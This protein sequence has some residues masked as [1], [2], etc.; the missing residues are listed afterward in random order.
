MSFLRFPAI[1]LGLLYLAACGSTSSSDGGGGGGDGSN[2]LAVGRCRVDADCDSPEQEYCA[3]PGEG[4]GCGV[5]F[6]GD[7]YGDA[8]CVDA[9]GA[10]YICGPLDDACAC[11]QSG[12]CRAGCA[13]DGCGLG[14]DC[15][16]D[17]R[18]VARTCSA[19]ADCGDEQLRCAG[20]K[21]KVPACLS[22]ADCSP[23]NTLCNL[24]SFSCYRVSCESDAD[25][26][27]YCVLGQCYDEAGECQPFVA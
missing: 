25:C 20:G 3:R 24:D 27:G 15:G 11:P 2:P 22:D 23:P 14:A 13:I 6:S 21:C 10:G 17:G 8:E 4:P 19:D 9:H 7:C 18:C 26:G 16:S 1:A 5:C 12:E